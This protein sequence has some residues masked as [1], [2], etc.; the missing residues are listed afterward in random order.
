MAKWGGPSEKSENLSPGLLRQRR[1]LI[2][3]SL[4]LI[5]FDL[6][7]SK[8][9]KVAILGM[10]LRIEQPTILVALAWTAWAY[11]FVRYLQ[12]MFAEPDL[13]IKSRRFRGWR[14]SYI[15]KAGF[16]LANSGGERIDTFRLRRAR[17]RFYVVSSKY[18]GANDR[19]DEI[20]QP[21]SIVRFAWH[22]AR[23]AFDMVVFEPY[24][25]DFILPIMIAIAA[26]LVVGWRATH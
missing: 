1:N 3:I 4:L 19:G 8:I 16:N 22:S 14:A 26:P 17:W 24:F 13:A 7:T 11:F 25:T 10:E 9:D 12:Y 5:V 2:A 20:E 15:S 6:S 23:A 21:I 18:G